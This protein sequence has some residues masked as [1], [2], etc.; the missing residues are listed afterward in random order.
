MPELQNI[1]DALAGCATAPSRGFAAA[2]ENLLKTLDYSSTRKAALSGD[3]D[4]FMSKY[5]AAE[6]E[7]AKQLRASAA[8]INIVFQFAETEILR[9]IE[10]T[11]GQNKQG[12]LIKNQLQESN[13][14]SFLFVAVD[15][16]KKKGGYS[17]SKYADLVREINKRFKPPTVVLFRR[18]ASDNAP[19]ALTLG[20][21]NRR[22]SQTKR[23]YDVLKKVSLLREVRCDKPHHGHLDILAKLSLAERFIWM[24]RKRKPQ[25][26]DGLLAAWLDELDAEALNRR[27]YKALYRWFEWAR[28]KAVFPCLPS[29]SC[30]KDEERD[31]ATADSVIR[32]I[33]RMMF[34]WFIK[35]KKLVAEDL[36]Y[37]EK[38]SPLLANYDADKGDTYYRA[39][40]QNLFFATLNTEI[41]DRGFNP[42]GQKGHRDGHGYRYKTLMTNPDKIRSL[43][44]QTPFINGGLFDCLDSEE[45]GG[46]RADMFSDP[47]PGTH[48]K[49]EAKRK[50]AFAALSVP[51]YLFFSEDDE[52]PG[53]LTIFKRYKFTVEENTPVEQ[54]V[55]LDPELLGKVFENLLAE[56]NPDTRESA[57]NQTGSFYTPRAVVDYMTDESLVA[58][59][60]AKVPDDDDSQ[61]REKLLDLLDYAKNECENIAQNKIAPLVRAIADIKVLDPACGSGAFPMGVFNKLALALSKLD[62]KN[63]EW[64]KVQEKRAT[65][66]AGKTF[67]SVQGRAKRDSRLEEI[68]KTFTKYSEPFGRKLFLIQN[69]I[70]GTDIQPIACQIAKL[71][72]FIS[73]AIE[74]EKKGTTK[75]NFGIRQL[76]NLET[77]FVAAD[78]LVRIRDIEEQGAL[79]DK[80][81]EQLREE[82]VNNRER[83]F[84]ARTRHAKSKCR[85]EDKRLRRLLA[86]ELQ[87]SGFVPPLAA[88]KI[89]DW[90]PYDPNDFANWFDPQWMFG[91]DDGFDVIIGNPPYRA[92]Q[93]ERG[94]LGNKY[95]GEEFLCFDRTSD[96][97]CLFYER[98][99]GLLSAGGHLAY[100][101]SNKFMRTNYG[102]KL[103]CLLADE[104]TLQT[105]IDFGE[106]PVFEAG[107]DPAIV[108]TKNAAPPKDST[109]TAAIIKNAVDVF[110]VDSAVARIGFGMLQSDLTESEWILAP[111]EVHALIRKMRCAG[112]PMRKYV[113][114]Q[115]QRG[116]TTGRDKA[117]VIDA[118]TRRQLIAED[119]NSAEL[120]KLYLLGGEI[121]QWRI[122]KPKQYV[123]F[124]LQDT[125][126]NS[127]PAVKKH[128]AKYRSSLVRR[129]APS[130]KYWYALQAS[131]TFYERFGDPK[132][133]Y[134]ETS[135]EIHSY[136]DHSGLYVNKTAFI[137]FAE[138][139]E[140]LLGVLNSKM[141]DFY[142]RHTFPCW[143]DPWN[144]GRIQFQGIRMAAVPIFPA[145]KPQR[146]KIARLVSEI[147]ESPQSASVPQLEAK[148]D[149]LVYKLYGLTEDEIALIKKWHNIRREAAQKNQPR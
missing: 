96:I 113:H 63:K 44:N 111:P 114:R 10:K 43:M 29:K 86:A 40:L 53:L 76:P 45:A 99:L 30:D 27:F 5:S 112:V 50:E 74:Q 89:A 72:F 82:L 66:A 140:Y 70:F 145:N 103:R 141:M 149:T 90:N 6:T 133:V 32:L 91:I 65:A 102:R 33:T 137:V 49:A 130:A 144:R 85:K 134:N 121:K 93:E 26:F 88:Q 16:R 67:A 78:T 123:I 92:L 142:Y 52:K 139:N 14:R 83:H 101:S 119:P 100:I 24:E 77:R 120:I 68:N 38:V 95:E 107:V 80:K 110:Q 2:A 36:F 122:E 109:L 39:I 97:Y 98:G 105:V 31:R 3:V 59:L 55:A 56:V 34:I 42:G 60:T 87:A 19:P 28:D 4:K 104:T 20:F 136:I 62:P 106:N 17:R 126:I 21:V 61:W 58:Y 148:I 147:L 131:G 129:A 128:L 69:S 37:E 18:P 46:F 143:G 124:T 116:I 118:E 54:E 108:I 1:Q 7:S 75:D 138:D 41:R 47:I 64:R 15:L 48:P 57:R 13:A 135:K 94:L 22:K 146:Q 23:G 25:N 132:I 51:N 73:L 8:N 117:F 81:I 84:N 35:E 127:Y 115:M 71:R 12:E 79:G 9:F 125:D 11:M